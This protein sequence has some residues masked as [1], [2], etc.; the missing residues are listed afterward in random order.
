MH[1]ITD[2]PAFRLPAICKDHLIFLIR[3]Q[4]INF[5]YPHAGK[6]TKGTRISAKIYIIRLIYDTA[7]ISQ[8]QDTTLL[9]KS[10]QCFLHAFLYHIKNRRCHYLVASKRILC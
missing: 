7:H 8:D 3:E 6:L 1:D 10:S 5:F 2:K 9:Y 4:G